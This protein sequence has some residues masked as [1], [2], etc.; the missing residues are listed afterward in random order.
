MKEQNQEGIFCI[1]QVLMR[2]VMAHTALLM[3]QAMPET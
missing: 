3:L 1:I 2:S